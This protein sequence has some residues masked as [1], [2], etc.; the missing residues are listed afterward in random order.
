MDSE[1]DNNYYYWN[2]QKLVCKGNGSNM[3]EAKKNACARVE[4][5]KRVPNESACTNKIKSI[6]GQWTCIENGAHVPHEW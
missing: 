2:Y 3:T 6:I 5:S 4:K 1:T